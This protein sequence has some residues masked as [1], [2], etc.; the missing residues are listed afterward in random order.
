MAAIARIRKKCKEI[1]PVTQVYRIY[2]PFIPYIHKSKIGVEDD[3]FLMEYKVYPLRGVDP[4]SYREMVFMLASISDRWF[5]RGAEPHHPSMVAWAEIYSEPPLQRK[6][7]LESLG[8]KDFFRKNPISAIRSDDIKL[9]D[10]I[11]LR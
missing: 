4:Y 11:P 3:R 6:I 9:P 2:E 8:L 1:D 10:P 7:T 5:K